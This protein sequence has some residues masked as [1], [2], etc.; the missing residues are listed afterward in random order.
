MITIIQVFLWS[1][2]QFT[3]NVWDI[4]CKIL[5]LESAI[6]LTCNEQCHI[7]FGIYS[8]TYDKTQVILF[9]VCYLASFENICCQYIK[10]LFYSL[11]KQLGLELDVL[12]DKSLDCDIVDIN[13]AS[14][15]CMTEGRSLTEAIILWISVL[16][17]N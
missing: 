5:A 4:L 9:P 17:Q 11:L 14:L 10:M 16:M 13:P 15:T 1:K 8:P 7:F 12:S 3:K 2:G 6:V